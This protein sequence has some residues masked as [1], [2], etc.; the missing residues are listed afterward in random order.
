MPK[1]GEYPCCH[2]ITILIDKQGI[3]QS[4]D[5]ETICPKLARSLGN[6]TIIQKGQTD[7]ISNGLPL[8]AALL[9]GSDAE[10]Q[11][12]VL[13]SDVQGGLKRVG[14]QGDI[15]SGSTGVLLAWGS[16]W[17]KGTYE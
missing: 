5:A 16:E 8:P 13:R 17:V 2:R 14:G 3:D 11:C 4:G 10:K 9:S 12:E 15:L 7:I 6:A 1:D